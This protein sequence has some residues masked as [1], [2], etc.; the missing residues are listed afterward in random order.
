MNKFL[1]LSFLT[2]CILIFI[3]GCSK[4]NPEPE[5]TDYNEK[6]L[7]DAY[8]SISNVTGIRSLVISYKHEIIYE[9]YYNNTNSGPDSII[10]IRSATK[11]I[12]SALIGI[13]IDKGF[14]NSV[15][16]TLSEFISPLVD[17]LDPQKGQ[18]TIHQLL[19]MTS[20]QEWSEIPGPSEFPDFIYA[21]DQFLYALNKPLINTPGTVFNYSD[22]SAH[23]LSVI[24]TQATG[25]TA[26][27]F[28]NKY[29]FEPLGIGNRFWYEDKQGYNYGGV[30]LCVGPYDM[31][32]FG[33][34]FLNKGKYKG[35]QIVSEN[36]VDKAITNYIST[37]NVLPYLT[38]YGYY[39]WVGTRKGFSFYTAMGYGGQYIFVVP[40]LN[41]VVVSTCNFT[42]IGGSVQAGENWKNITD[43]IMN[44]ILE[45][46][47][48]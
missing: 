22:G 32:K 39:W 30:G 8:K 1:T 38:N 41:L 14:I 9:E 35:V 20:G 7:Q 37:G 29:L 36:W 26:S 3:I 24:L 10:D 43:I 48:N 47:V 15:D 31:I 6:K 25:M 16:Q 45:A 13:A 42:G 11:S 5:N 23:L 34:L 40:D 4:S 2:A 19:T 44:N 46:F 21:P 33:N 17:S 12:L 28:A 27:Q 18:I